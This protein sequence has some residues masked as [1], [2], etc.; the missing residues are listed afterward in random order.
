MGESHL[1]E[2]NALVSLQSQSL[3]LSAQQQQLQQLQMLHQQLIQQSAMLQHPQQQPQQP[4]IDSNL[5]AQIQALTNQLL[6]KTQDD[7]KP[8]EP[9]FN[10][11]RCECSRQPLVISKQAGRFNEENHF[12][13][14]PELGGHGNGCKVLTLSVTST[15]IKFRGDPLPSFG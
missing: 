12:E 6:Q 7:G 13:V 4:L 1:Y 15:I 3:S 2:C 8:P 10:K 14:Y 9:T 5:L 11:V